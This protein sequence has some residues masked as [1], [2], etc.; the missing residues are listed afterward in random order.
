LPHHQADEHSP[1]RAVCLCA[2]DFGLHAGIAPAI[3]PLA[4]MGRVT[5]IGAMVGAP[6][7]AA[8]AP[9]LRSLDA[10]AIDIG[11]HLDLTEYPLMPQSRR[12]L[13]ALM[14]AA[15]LRSID[16]RGVRAEIGAQ[17]NAFELALGRRPAYVD[18][19]R[20]VHQL[21]IV[22]DELL[23]ELSERYGRCAIWL[24]S[25][26]CGMTPAAPRATSVAERAKARLLGAAGASGLR[27]LA[28]HA[29]Y[30][31]N[32]C[33]LGVYGFHGGAPR[34]AGL[35]AAWLRAAQS[36]DLLMCHP[37]LDIDAADPIGPS[38]AAE[39]SVL[40]STAF[41][42]LLRG[43]AVSLEPMSRILARGTL[44]P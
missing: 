36:G 44:P 5:A 32:R 4:Q 37:G 18:G 1:L 10:G 28:A 8:A 14:A 29:G 7:W 19:H 2:D 12:S 21:P 13:P 23:T 17:L 11:L 16:R 39:Y 25:T 41:G 15:G 26:R 42:E 20:H 22:R 24:R 40:R 35:M 9:A 3:L 6:A 33:L 30:A 27:A 34:Y 31:Q 38:R 43:Q